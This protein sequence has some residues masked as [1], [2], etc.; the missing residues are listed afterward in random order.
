MLW[1]LS[2]QRCEKFGLFFIPTSGHTGSGQKSMDVNMHKFVYLKL[3]HPINA[4][5]RLG[6]LLCNSI[7][8]QLY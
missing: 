1:T 3:T 7:Y 5:S 6:K 4:L 2:G 8:D